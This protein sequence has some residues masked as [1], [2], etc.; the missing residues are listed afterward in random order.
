MSNL[1]VALQ[2][3]FALPLTACQPGGREDIRIRTS[4]PGI[5]RA[6]ALNRCAERDVLLPSPPSS[7]YPS[8]SPSRRFHPRP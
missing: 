6:T 1:A 3:K 7:L 2:V 8:F 4:S 5:A